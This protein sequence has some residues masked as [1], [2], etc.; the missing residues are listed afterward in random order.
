[1]N[2][3]KVCFHVAKLKKMPDKISRLATSV[4]RHLIISREKRDFLLRFLTIL[5]ILRQY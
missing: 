3:E 1:M 5:I 4:V 2:K